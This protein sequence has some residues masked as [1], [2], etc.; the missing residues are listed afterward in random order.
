MK[1]KN[2]SETTFQKYLQGIVRRRYIFTR[3]KN[4]VSNSHTTLNQDSRGIIALTKN[5]SLNNFQ[6][7]KWYNTIIHEKAHRYE[8]STN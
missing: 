6:W 2:N 3:F 7:K 4:L 8:K 5:T 1:L